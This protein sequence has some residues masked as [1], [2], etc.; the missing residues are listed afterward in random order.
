MS[1]FE[2][3][4]WVAIAIVIL[5]VLYIASHSFRKSRLGRNVGKYVDKDGDGRPFR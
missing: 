1:L 2:L 5:L 3:I 4:V